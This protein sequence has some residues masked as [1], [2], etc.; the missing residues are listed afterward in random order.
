MFTHAMTSKHK[1]KQRPIEKTQDI[2]LPTVVAIRDL[3]HGKCI[4]FLSSR[5][6][7]TPHAPALSEESFDEAQESPW[8]LDPAVFVLGETSHVGLVV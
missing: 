1:L 3:P 8:C 7:S 2:F 5:S 6:C 4:V